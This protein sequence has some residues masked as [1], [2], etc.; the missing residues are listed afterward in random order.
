MNTTVSYHIKDVS[1]NTLIPGTWFTFSGS[2]YLLFGD[3]CLTAGRD[4]IKAF[5]AHDREILHFSYN[6]KVIPVEVAEIIV[7]GPG[8]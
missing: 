8:K 7:R 6:T 5:R 1:L 4:M 3:P 2:L